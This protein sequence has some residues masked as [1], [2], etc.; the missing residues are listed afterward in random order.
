MTYIVPDADPEPSPDEPILG[1]ARIIY[2]GPFAPHWDVQS[3]SG[4]KGLMDAFRDRVIARL[5]LL[6]PHDPQFRRNRDRVMRDAER[7]RIDVEW[8]LG[9][10]EQAVDEAGEIGQ[11]IS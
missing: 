10:V 3:I 11:A 1:Q 9:S 8:D 5:T 2:L 4:D 6:P 7:E